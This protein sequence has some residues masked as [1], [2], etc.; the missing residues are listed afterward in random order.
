MS[1]AEKNQSSD[2]NVFLNYLVQRL[3]NDVNPIT[4][5]PGHTCSLC[6]WL[7]KITAQFHMEL[8]SSSVFGQVH[9][10]FIPQAYY[11]QFEIK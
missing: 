8:S 2:L 5:I 4:D 7:L 10:F 9:F 6:F 1:Q 11:I 3:R